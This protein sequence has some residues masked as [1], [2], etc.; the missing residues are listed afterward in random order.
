MRAKVSVIFAVSV[1][2]IF[3][4]AVL[5]LNLSIRAKADVAGMD[6]RGLSRDG[7]FKKAVQTIVGNCTVDGRNIIC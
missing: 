3:N 7:D 6:W 5:A 2:T 4:I 1:L